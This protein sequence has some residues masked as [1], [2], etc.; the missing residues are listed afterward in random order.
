MSSIFSITTNQTLQLHLQFVISNIIYKSSKIFYIVGALYKV[1][2]CVIAA[3]YIM[4]IIIKKFEATKNLLLA[5][6]MRRLKTLQ[7]TKILTFS[8]CIY[9]YFMMNKNEKNALF[10]VHFYILVLMY[11]EKGSYAFI[12]N[13]KFY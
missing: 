3:R 10:L 9:V 4:R 7:S 11:V 1:F 6:D 2:F 13:I 12:F 5:K 8:K